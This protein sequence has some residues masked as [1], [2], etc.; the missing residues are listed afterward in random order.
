MA[1]APPTI[2]RLLNL[3]P[4]SPGTVLTLLQSNSQLAGER[5]AHGY[6]LV[7]AAASYGH[8][9]LL[10]A[11]IKDYGVDPNICDEDDETA[12]FSVEDV[13]TAKELIELGTDMNKRNMDG[14]LA[15]EKLA[16]EDEQPAVAAYLREVAGDDQTA[17][18][19]SAA[20]LSNGDA[21]GIHPPPPPLPEGLQL[22]V[23]TMHAGDA[24]DEPDPE[25][26]RRIEEL[27]ARGDFEG[28]EGQRELRELVMQAISGVANEAQA[29][30]ATRRR[31]D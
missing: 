24:G 22:N 27:A 13:A 19:A 21:N 6:S 9:E 15:A 17:A 30:P 20:S 29:P 23:G 4:D 12:L 28:E 8:V 26:R 7:H 10:R 14:Q 31:L 1:Q 11:L 3:V 16:D 2:D 25:F 5:D 18:A